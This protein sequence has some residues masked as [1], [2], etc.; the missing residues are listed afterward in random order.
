MIIRAFITHKKAEKFVDCQDRFGVNPDTKSLA[1]SDGMGASWQQK[2]WAQILVEEFIRSKDWEP[3]HDTIKPL[4]SLWRNKVEASIAHLKESNAPQ[5]LI[6]RNERSLAEGRSAGATFVG[7]RFFNNEWKGS[8]LGDSCL[9]DWNGKEAIFYTSQEGDEFDSYPDYFDSDQNKSG[10]GTPLTINGTLTKESHLLLVS[11]PFSDFL[12]EKKKQENIAEYISQLLSISNHEDFEKL[13]DDWRHI[14]MHNDDTTL[15]IVEDDNKDNFIVVH[16][17]S[18][19]KLKELD[20]LPKVEP[21]QNNPSENSKEQVKANKCN[22]S[23][24]NEDEN[25]FVKELREWLECSLKRVKIG[26]SKIKEFLKRFF[27]KSICKIIERYKIT[28][29]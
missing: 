26:N 16:E 5:N 2:I 8:V 13:V 19:E 25:D 28:K 23:L 29:R 12:L 6:F 18:I 9:I 27:D 7:I 10:K 17:D 1:V 20:E 11:D 3:S 21:Q 15:V 4:C 24:M 22:Q 14:G